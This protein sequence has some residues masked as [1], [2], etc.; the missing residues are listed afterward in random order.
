MPALPCPH[1]CRDAPRGHE[2]EAY[3]NG[4][5]LRK[6][7]RGEAAAAVREKCIE[8]HARHASCKVEDKK[9]GFVT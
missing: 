6:T 9:R 1:G 3:T 7:E 4:R 2:R 8:L 5:G